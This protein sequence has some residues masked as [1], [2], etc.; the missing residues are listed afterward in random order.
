LGPTCDDLTKQT[1]AECFGLP[2]IFHEE[3]AE[4]IR[5]YFRSAG[6]SSMPESNLSQAMLPEGCT[7]LRNHNGTAPGCAFF[8]GGKHV[9][10]L[11]GPPRELRVMLE[12]EA[13]PYLSRFPPL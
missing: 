3:E 4:R 7:V 5:A 11:P 2:L 13:L 8:S 6:S 9:L 1:L 12:R 10:M